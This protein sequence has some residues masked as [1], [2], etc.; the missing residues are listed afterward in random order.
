MN[1]IVERLRGSSGRM[2]VLIKTGQLD[3]TSDVG[4]R[5][6]CAQHDVLL[7]ALGLTDPPE[8]T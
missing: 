1:D 8:G 3:L 6:L 5:S 4:L 2:L 7:D